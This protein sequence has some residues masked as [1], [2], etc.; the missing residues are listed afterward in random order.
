MAQYTHWPYCGAP[1][2]YHHCV[3]F[4]DVFAHQAWADASLLTAVQAHVP[5]QEDEWLQSTLHHI[6]SVQRYFLSRFLDREFDRETERRP[7]GSFGDLVRLFRAT[8]EEELALVGRLSEADLERRFE[9]PF[10][11]TEFT[12]A[13]GLTQ[14]VMHSQNHR[15]QCLRYL[16]KHGAEPPTLDYILWARDR[17]AP[18]WPQV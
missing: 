6:V 16:R 15:G 11:R 5:S 1:Q 7:P 3:N 4:R 13:D 18:A 2:S 17:A 8:H 10:L 14:V 12:M 9:L